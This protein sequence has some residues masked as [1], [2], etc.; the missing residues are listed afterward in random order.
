MP[1]QSKNPATLEILKTF[2]EITDEEL[3]KKISLG[4][5]A[6]KKWK[7]RKISKSVIG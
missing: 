5:T 7:E 1:I 2:P 4:S 3:E 6:F